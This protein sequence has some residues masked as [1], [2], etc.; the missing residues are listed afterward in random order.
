MVLGLGSM[1]NHSARGQNIGWERNLQT[2]CITYRALQ[3]IKA[4]EELCINYG[5]LWFV[6]ADT[7]ESIMEENALDDLNHIELP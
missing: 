7:D 2:Q 1:F 6:D 3:D 4:G 5:R